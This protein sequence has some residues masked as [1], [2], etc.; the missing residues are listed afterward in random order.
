MV[1][2]VD[3]MRYRDQDTLR[4]YIAISPVQI[5]P[6]VHVFLHGRKRAFHLYAAVHPELDPP[7]TLVS[8]PVTFSSF[9]FLQV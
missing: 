6:E 9:P 5:L 1:E 3:V 2:F 8:V 4:Q 7:V